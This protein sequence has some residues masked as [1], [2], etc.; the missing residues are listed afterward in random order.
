MHVV[1]PKL[2]WHCPKMQYKITKCS[3]TIVTNSN[4]TR[5]YIIGF[6]QGRISFVNFKISD[7]V[8]IELIPFYSEQ[9]HNYSS[10]LE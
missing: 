7:L 10:V 3:S 8:M 5:P 9:T 1:E 6:I 4:P 2:K